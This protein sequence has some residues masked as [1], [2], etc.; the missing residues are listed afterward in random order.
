MR[1]VRAAGIRDGRV[2]E[3]V[4]ATPRAGFVPAGWVGAAYEDMPVPIGHGQVTTQP[5]LLARMIEALGPGGDE[6]VLEVG[7]GLGFQTALLARLAGDVVSVELWADLTEEAR[8]NLAALGIGNVELRTGD[9]GEGVPDLA[10]F[11]AV[12]VSAAFPEVPPPLVEQLRLGG[13]LV[14][15][16]GPGGQE[17]VVLFRRTAAG[18]A[19]LRV[20]TPACFVRLHGR[21]GFPSDDTDA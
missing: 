5:S 20:L 12:I 16:I 21:Y 7:T 13:R 3:A 4:R 11:D 15:P 10:P 17:D 1:A 8:G 14:Q 9:G 19:P 2:L 18:L 6:H